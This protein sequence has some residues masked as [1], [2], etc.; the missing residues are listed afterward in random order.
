MTLLTGMY[1]LATWS[2]PPGAAQ[3]SIQHFAVSRKLYFLFSWMSLKAER[4]RYP[5]SLHTGHTVNIEESEASNGNILCKFVVFIKAALACLFLG[6][7]HRGLLVTLTGPT[8]V[9][10]V[11]AVNASACTSTKIFAAGD[12][13]PLQAPV[14]GLGPVSACRPPCARRRACR[15]GAERSFQFCSPTDVDLEFLQQDTVRILTTTYNE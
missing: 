2:H 15:L 12:L 11:A 13:A 6:L 14:L 10:A 8:E 1:L 4:A 7:T 5:C 3:R 9:V